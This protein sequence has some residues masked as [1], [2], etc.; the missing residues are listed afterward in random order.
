[1]PVQLE[2]RLIDKAARE[3]AVTAAVDQVLLLGY[4]GRD[5]ASVVQ[6]I[7]ELS[8]LGVAPPPRVPMIYE[9][10]PALL[11]TGGSITV[12]SDKTAGEAELYLAHTPAGLCVGVGS[13]HTDREQEAIDVARS[14]ALCSKVVSREVWLCEEVAANWDELQL[15]AWVTVDGERRLYQDGGLADFAPLAALLDE[16][17][18][19]GYQVLERTVIFGGTLSLLGGFAYAQRF[20]AE[21][22]DPRTGRSLSCAY[23]VVKLG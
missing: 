4:T 5:R 12:Q 2:L 20:E 23:D 13:D 7:E 19:A 9:V 17:E 18:R 11:T 14:K 8:R 16:V 3:Q 22:R 15:R 10:P 1:M 21:L 6:H